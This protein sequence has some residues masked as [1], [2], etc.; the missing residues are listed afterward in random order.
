MKSEDWA[1]KQEQAEL[2]SALL[3]GEL[4]GPVEQQAVNELLRGDAA[5]RERSARYCMIGDA[6]RGES[7]IDATTIAARVRDA[8]EDEPVVLAP[9]PNPAPRWI[10]PVS[11]AALA[12]SVAAVAI[13]F[14]PGMMTTAPDHGVSTVTIAEAP[15]P[16]VVPVAT[17]TEPARVLEDPESELASSTPDDRWQAIDPVLQDRLNRLLIEHH[18]FSGRTGVRGP[19]SHVGLVDYDGR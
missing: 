7:L 8:L 1:M 16:Q 5:D 12:A 10:K 14:A 9:S 13:V 2:A 19:V 17:G 6:M 4:D 15:T 18:E 11:G 3:D